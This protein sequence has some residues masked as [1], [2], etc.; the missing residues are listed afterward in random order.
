MV[1]IA[2]QSKVN[3]MHH[4][5]YVIKLFID[6][7]YTLY[8]TLLQQIGRIY[9]FIITT[10]YVCQSNLSNSRLTSKHFIFAMIAGILAFLFMWGCLHCTHVFTIL[11]TFAPLSQVPTLLDGIH[12]SYTIYIRVIICRLPKKNSKSN[13]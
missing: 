10:K 5:L 7:T 2:Q 4:A 8:T 6:H 12:T 11:H 1:T 13:S 9:I 3:F